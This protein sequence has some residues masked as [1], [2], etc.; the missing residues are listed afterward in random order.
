LAYELVPGLTVMPE[1]NYRK[2]NDVHSVLNDKDA[3]GG[4]IRIQ[5]DF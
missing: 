5:R 3:I 1:V 2:W 4:A